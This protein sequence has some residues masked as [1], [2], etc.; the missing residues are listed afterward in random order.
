MESRIQVS[1][2]HFVKKIIQLVIILGFNSVH[3]SLVTVKIEAAG[4]LN[5]D[6]IQKWAPGFGS[7]GP[8]ALNWD[9]NNDLFTELLA[10]DRGYSGGAA[11]F[12]WYGENCALQLSV[13]AINTKIHLQTFTLGYF[14]FGS[15]VQYSVT[16]LATQS[17]IM[18]GAPWIESDEPSLITVNATSDKGFLILFGPDGFNGGINNITYSYDSFPGSI[19]VQTPIPASAWLFCLGLFG[20]IH[21]TRQSRILS[22]RRMSGLSFNCG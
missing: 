5:W 16:D 19:P 7:D 22:I 11:A 10:Y 12:C 2:S 20:L 17:S 18:A 6:P 15:N 3:A 13:T 1:I 9:P 14:G 8:V 21:F 4:V